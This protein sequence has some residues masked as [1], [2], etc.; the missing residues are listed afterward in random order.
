MIWKNLS[1]LALGALAC[2]SVA[3]SGN[4]KD[5]LKVDAA[6]EYMHVGGEYRFIDVPASMYSAGLN[7]NADYSFAFEFLNISRVGYSLR[8]IGSGTDYQ[9]ISSNDL[10]HSSYTSM[11]YYPNWNNNDTYREIRITDL[12]LSSLGTTF[13]RWFE[14]NTILLNAEP[15]YSSGV[16]EGYS[17]GY[18]AG[19]S[20]GYSEGY[21]SGHS[22]GY[23][24]GYEDGSADAYHDGAVDGYSEGYASGQSAGNSEGYNSGYSAGYSAGAQSQIDFPQSITLRWAADEGISIPVRALTY[25]YGE[26]SASST[27]SFTLSA[28]NRTF[29]VNRSTGYALLLKFDIDVTAEKPYPAFRFYFDDYSQTLSWDMVR[30]DLIYCPTWIPSLV[31]DV[32]TNND[33]TLESDFDGLMFDSRW[34]GDVL[35]GPRAGADELY[36]QGFRDGEQV[37]YESGQDAG[38]SQGQSAG[39]SW[40]YG[41]GY[42]AGVAAG[43]GTMQVIDIWGLMSA[44]ITMPFTFFSQGLDWTLFAGSPYEFSV[45]IFFGSLLVILMLWKIIQ[46]VIGLGK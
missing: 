27:I 4:I 42:S 14:A 2:L 15:S 22:A 33:N 21:N 11:F 32:W 41:A 34:Y 10:A 8:G 29:T 6:D 45:S 7:N 18:S 43:G 1:K 39:Y 44:V 13:K 35:F 9:I 28:E 19:H 16:A 25:P 40:G 36:S 5:V 31:V 12:S 20:A 23:S 30:S 37:G 46:L 3:F 26:G 38:Y 24:E 17:S